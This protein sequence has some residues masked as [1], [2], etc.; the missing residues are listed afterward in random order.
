MQSLKVFGN[1]ASPY[2]QKL[3]TYLR[4][5]NIKYNVTW[6][7]VKTNLE[8]LNKIPPS[9]ILLPT[10]LLNDDSDPITDTTPIIRILEEKFK[11]KSVIPIDPKLAFIN[12][13]IED[14]ADEWLTKFMF[15]F[16][17]SFDKDILNAKNKLT[18][19]HGVTVDNK[20]KDQIADFISQKQISRLWV[21]GSNEKTKDFIEQNYKSFLTKLDICL[22]NTPF[23]L[24][25]RPSSC[26]FAI[27]GQLSQLVNF[28]PTSRAIASDIS[29]R[30]S[31]WTDLMSDLSGYHDQITSESLI[32]KKTFMEA[33]YFNDNDDGWNNLE[34]N[35]CLISLIEEIGN[36]YLPYLKANHDALLDNSKTFSLELDNAV[37][38]QKTFPYQSKCY[39]WIKDEFNK[40][41]GDNKSAIAKCI[42]SN[43]AQTLIN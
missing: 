43:G 10:V 29:L 15:H 4:Y 5:K 8:L 38:E 42:G 23:L 3:I 26:D 6:G 33:N 27:F 12:Y 31:A 1:P 21:V 2:T 35:K 22:T 13:L 37:W 16:R 40:L 17:W 36:I 20:S 39:R 7:D 34:N 14:Y 41:S 19:L 32:N 30:V 11:N 28:D 18:F 25:K 24:G 9:P